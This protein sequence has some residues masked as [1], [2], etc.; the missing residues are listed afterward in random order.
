MSYGQTQIISFPQCMTNVY[1]TTPVVIEEF[2]RL[3]RRHTSV[4]APTQ[5]TMDQC[6]K[7]VENFARARARARV[8]GVRA[9]CTMVSLY[10]CQHRCIN[11]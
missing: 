1:P 5:I 2:V 9:D 7:Q 3:L 11:S 10:L 4:T 8:C 6:V